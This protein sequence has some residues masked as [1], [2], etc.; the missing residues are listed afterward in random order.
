MADSRS[1][2]QPVAVGLFGAGGKMGLAIAELIGRDFA[3]SAQLVAAVSSNDPLDSLAD[4]DVILDFSLL[5][6]TQRLLDWLRSFNG[7]PPTLVCG[8]TG[9][10]DR[11]FADLDDL[12]RRTRVLQ[13]NNFSAG[14]AALSAIIEQAAPILRRLGYTP[15]LTETHHRSKKD[16]PSGTAKTLRDVL[17]PQYPEGLAVHSIRA[18]EVIGK[19]DVTFYGSDDEIVIGHDAKDRRLF[20]RGAIEAALWLCQ[21]PARHGRFTM[22]TYFRERYLN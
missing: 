22:E 1:P 19:H 11:A 6:G 15:V 12:S 10:D 17:E 9:L 3:E 14:V 2:A 13:S 18:G 7:V 8:T 4:A 20:A 5:S 21:R 16:A